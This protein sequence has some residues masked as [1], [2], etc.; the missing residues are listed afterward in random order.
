MTVFPC[1]L[2]MGEGGSADIASLWFLLKCGRGRGGQV[3]AQLDIYLWF[4]DR[5]CGTTPRGCPA[6]DPN[7]GL[8]VFHH[9]LPVDFI[10][11]G[12]KNRG[13]KL[14]RSERDKQRRS[15]IT[16]LD[17]RIDGQN[18]ERSQTRETQCGNV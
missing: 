4:E 2:Q 13:G 10:D 14:T 11:V 9:V 3:K 17:E 15:V 7:W 8:P 16:M 6:Q 1:R 18:P 12:D 5:P